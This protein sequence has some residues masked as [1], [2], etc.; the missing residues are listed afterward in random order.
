[1]VYVCCSYLGLETVHSEE[2]EKMAEDHGVG[3][4]WSEC[5]TIDDCL[6]PLVDTWWK[7]TLWALAAALMFII[8]L[9]ITR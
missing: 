5:Q 3:G 7:M 2:A 6:A 9:Y 4:D 8:Y 1:M